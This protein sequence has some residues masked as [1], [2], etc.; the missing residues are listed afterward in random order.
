MN[1]QV[2]IERY[3]YVLLVLVPVLLE[4]FVYVFGVIIRRDSSS[5]WKHHDE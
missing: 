5:A 4:A 3:T 1:R 2:S